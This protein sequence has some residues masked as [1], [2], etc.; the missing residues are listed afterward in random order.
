M[1]LLK[2][3]DGIV[4]LV[5]LVV[6]IIMTLGAMSIARSLD[7]S[8]LIAGNLAFRQ[9]AVYSGD[10]GTETAI[11]W[12][13]GGAASALLNDDPDNGYWAAA[14]TVVP[15][16]D[17]TWDKFW[18]E[19]LASRARTL[20]KDAVGNTVSYVIDRMCPSSGSTTDCIFLPGSTTSSSGGKGENPVVLRGIP[21]VV[22]RI[23]ARIDGPRNTV[24][25]VQTN[26]AK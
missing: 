21:Q 12:L 23:T 5:T 24:A 7:S 25:Y 20:S 6:L 9:S 22:Y 10:V 8:T 4:L 15:A 11:S 18:S 19:S 2:K 13:D 14:V 1:H 17:K 3:Q 26:V 16:T